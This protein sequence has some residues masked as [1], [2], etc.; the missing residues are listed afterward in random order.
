MLKRLT[1]FYSGAEEIHEYFKWVAKKFGQISV[2]KQISSQLTALSDCYKYISLSHQVT[3]AKWHDR[4]Q[5]DLKIKTPD[6]NTITDYA[7][8]LVNANGLLNSWQWPNIK[9]FNSFKGP[10]MHSAAWD[11]KVPITKD[12][13]VGI[14]GNGS[15][16]G[17]S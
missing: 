11:P 17:T 16:V 9:G 12:T 14:I 5:W 10:K 8:V 3:S 15:S 2:R 13:S 1:D 4:G 7:D 6:G